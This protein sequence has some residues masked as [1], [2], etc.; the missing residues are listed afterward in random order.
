MSQ[1]M[2][3]SHKRSLKERERPPKNSSSSPLV[4]L[5]S[6]LFPPLLSFCSQY[7]KHMRQQEQKQPVFQKTKTKKKRKTLQET[8]HTRTDPKRES[9]VGRQSVEPVQ[10]EPLQKAQT[11]ARRGSLLLLFF[12][13]PAGFKEMSRGTGP[14]LNPCLICMSR[15]SCCCC[16]GGGGCCAG[17][18]AIAPVS[19]AK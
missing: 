12:P 7:Q 16:C 6:L 13:S 8:T 9:Q 18:G 5:F 2:I 19:C 1:I 15:G 4:A 17:D 11:R 14:R 10:S 3:E